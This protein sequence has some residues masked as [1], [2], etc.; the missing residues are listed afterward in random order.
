MKYLDKELSEY[1]LQEL[2]LIWCDLQEAEAK[3]EKASRHLKFD[4]VNNKKAM[5]F[6]PPNPNF[7]ILKDAIVEEIKRKENA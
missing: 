4:K 6:P 7:L 5:E 3:R 2:E 1:T